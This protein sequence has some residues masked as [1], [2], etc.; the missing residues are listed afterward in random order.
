MPA[1][2][3]LRGVLNVPLVRCLRPFLRQAQDRTGQPFSTGPKQVDAVS[4]VAC[5]KAIVDIHHPDS[6]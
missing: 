2:F 1:A 4:Q 5:T 3:S 6:P